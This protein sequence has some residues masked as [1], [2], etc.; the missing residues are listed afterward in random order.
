MELFSF[1]PASVDITT[2]IIILILT[3]IGVYWFW[4]KPSLSSSTPSNDI[5]KTINDLQT[6]ID[7]LV[8]EHLLKS[9]FLVKI[10]EENH[11]VHLMRVVLWIV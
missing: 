5:I 10:Q 8:F 7:L 9:L 2:L 1:I 3:L 11:Q 6:Y 4:L